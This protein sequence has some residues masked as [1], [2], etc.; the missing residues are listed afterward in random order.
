[1]YVYSYILKGFAPC[2]RPLADRIL[3]IPYKIWVLKNN[4][5]RSPFY[6]CHQNVISGRPNPR[7]AFPD[8]FENFDFRPC[9]T[10]P[11]PL[12]Q[13]SPK[14]SQTHPNMSQRS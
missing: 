12:L 14:P 10:P 4:V 5:S 6:V 13:K 7:K 2:R 9:Q 8:I 11:K 3:I 1:M